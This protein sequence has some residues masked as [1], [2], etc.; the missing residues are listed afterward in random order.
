MLGPGAATNYVAAAVVLVD[1]AFVRQSCQGM[2]SGGPADPKKPADL[3]LAQHKTVG[4]TAGK[5]LPAQQVV[6]RILKPT[7]LSRTR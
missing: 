2:A 7:A 5:D 4:Q 6:N 1:Q 3:S